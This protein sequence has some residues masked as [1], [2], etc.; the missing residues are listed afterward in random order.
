M[1]R[2]IL[3]GKTVDGV[4]KELS[5]FALAYNLVCAVRVDS[6]RAQRVSVERLGFLDAARHLRS[7]IPGGDV[8][9]IWINPARPDRIE[10]RVLNRRKNRIF[11]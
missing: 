1:K 2:D 9:K 6:A 7:P 5:R 10:P 11:S 4:M 8:T 3:H